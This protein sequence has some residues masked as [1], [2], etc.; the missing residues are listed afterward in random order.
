MQAIFFRQNCHFH[1][2]PGNNSPRP[3]PAHIPPKQLATVGKAQSPTA[4]AEP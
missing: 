1:I 3:G 4:C 2:K